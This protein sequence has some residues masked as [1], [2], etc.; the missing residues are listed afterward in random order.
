MCIPR[1]SRKCDFFF[2]RKYIASREWKNEW[3]SECMNVR[4]DYHPNISLIFFFFCWFHLSVHRRGYT[5]EF[6]PSIFYNSTQTFSLPN[7]VYMTIFV[8]CWMGFG[9]YHHYPFKLEES[10]SVWVYIGVPLLRNRVYW[11][12]YEGWSSRKR[13]GCFSWRG[14]YIFYVESLKC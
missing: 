9:L 5:P 3:M 14:K 4:V 7:Y 6:W 12:V 10:L 2:P 11:D 8:D 13:K 1:A